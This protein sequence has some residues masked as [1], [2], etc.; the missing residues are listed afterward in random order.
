MPTTQRILITGAN[1]RIG[2]TLREGLRGR[3]A[4]L[5]L[6][7]TAPINDLTEGEEAVVADVTSDDLSAAMA[8][9]D[10]VIHLAA[11]V[12]ELPFE[13]LFEANILGVSRAFE[14]A[15]LAGVTRLIYASSVQATGFHPQDGGVDQATRIR[16]SGF[17]GVCKAAGEALGSV[18]ADKYGLS[19]ACLRI[20]SFEPKPSDSRQLRTWLSPADCVRLVAACIDAAAFS[21]EIVYG[22][23]ANSRT[24]VRDAPPSAIDYRP[25]DDGEAYADRVTPAEGAAK[26]FIGGPYAGVGFIGNFS[27]VPGQSC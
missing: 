15:R 7:D 16:P 26:R 8:G 5:R 9:I 22:V 10:C 18:Y 21:F 1:G 25:E 27:R 12:D 13:Q 24:I 19:V 4:L 11:I 14:A 6:L 20:A 17:Y 23:S 3:Y 2:R